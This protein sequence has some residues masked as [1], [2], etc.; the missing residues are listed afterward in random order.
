VIALL[1]RTVSKASSTSQQLA[2][3]PATAS[4]Y[5]ASE[6]ILSAQRGYSDMPKLKRIV[7]KA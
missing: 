2:V 7:P 3:L 1:A 4:I 5:I 6:P